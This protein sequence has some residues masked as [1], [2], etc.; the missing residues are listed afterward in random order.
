MTSGQKI[1]YHV[2]MG[3]TVEELRN[4]DPVTISRVEVADLDRITG[5]LDPRDLAKLREIDVDPAKV[6]WF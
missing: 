2:R 1:W 3:K 4:L 5:E 6:F